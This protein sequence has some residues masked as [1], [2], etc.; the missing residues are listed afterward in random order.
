MKTF[1][2]SIKTLEENQESVTKDL[3]HSKTEF[4]QTERGWMAEKEFL[5]RKLQFVQ[6]YGSVIPPSIDGGGYFTDQRSGLRKGGDLKN[7]RDVQKH[8]VIAV[9][10]LS[11]YLKV[12]K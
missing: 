11:N 9:N 12:L 4:R 5:M 10:L 2:C 3:V 7:H 1:S 8:N 6:H